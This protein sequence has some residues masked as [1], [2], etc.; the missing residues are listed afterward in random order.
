MWL[1]YI[2]LCIGGRVSSRDLARTASTSGHLSD[3]LGRASHSVHLSFQLLGM[4]RARLSLRHMSMGHSL[5]PALSRSLPC[6]FSECLSTS[7]IAP[8]FGSLFSTLLSKSRLSCISWCLF[9]CHQDSEAR[10]IL[11]SDLFGESS[12]RAWWVSLL[13]GLLAFLQLQ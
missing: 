11:S 4:H 9:Y 10:V 2:D 13:L 1:P 12:C 5:P 6:M 8:C 3:K 7:D